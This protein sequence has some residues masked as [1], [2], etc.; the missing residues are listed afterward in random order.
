M[1]GD[2]RR[3]PQSTYQALLAKPQAG[4]TG[5]GAFALSKNSTRR[6]QQRAHRPHSRGR[7]RCTRRAHNGD[8]SFAPPM[9]SATNR[10][11][12]RLMATSPC[13]V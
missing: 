1:T 6:E 8:G 2:P 12:I 3:P 4:G 5:S 11:S 7:A 9:Y 13:R 10:R